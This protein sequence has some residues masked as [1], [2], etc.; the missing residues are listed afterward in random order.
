[1][2]T[3]HSRLQV[4]RVTHSNVFLVRM[5]N[6]RLESISTAKKSIL[7]LGKLE[8]LVAKC[9]KRKAVS[10]GAIFLATSSAILLPNFRLV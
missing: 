5:D 3:M 1:M 6:N 4:K 9:C 7:K 2:A 8:G 10:H